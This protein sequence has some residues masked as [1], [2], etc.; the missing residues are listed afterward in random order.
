MKKVVILLVLLICQLS[1]SHTVSGSLNMASV[2]S[3]DS[4]P[5][6]TLRKNT[7]T[8]IADT[9][10]H[11]VGGEKIKER[12]NLI[13]CYD[14]SFLTIYFEC[15]DNPRVNQNHFKNNNDPLFFQEVLE[16]FIC[17]GAL[18]LEKY[19]EIQINPN[20]AVFLAQITNNYLSDKKFSVNLMDVSSS[21]IEHFVEKDVLQQKWSGWIKLPF[22]LL[23]YPELNSVNA[24]RLNMFRI[25]SNQD[26]LS[27]QWMGSAE[28]STFACWNSTLDVKPNFHNPNYFGYLILEDE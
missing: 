3:R 23:N 27:P 8:P 22:A 9:F 2:S 12:T 21:G 11:S 14:N 15:L 6:I 28:N 1:V 5:T 24:F 19:L 13:M 26:Q 7:L 17:N 18:P 10:S 4:L 16:V 25:I 20:N